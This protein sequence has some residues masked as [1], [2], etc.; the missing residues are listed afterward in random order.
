[1]SLLEEPDA[2][3][4]EYRAIAGS[5]ASTFLVEKCY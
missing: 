3:E 1:M 2:N 4:A 5:K